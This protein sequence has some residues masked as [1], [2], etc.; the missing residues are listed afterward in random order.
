MTCREM[1]I[2]QDEV[3][4][5]TVLNLQF[6]NQKNSFGNGISPHKFGAITHV[7]VKLD[8]NFWEEF[9]GNILC[10]LPEIINVLIFPISTGSFSIM[11]GIDSHNTF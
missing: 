7:A 2:A 11:Y 10:F 8:R 6:Q 1:V 4:T 9:N 3:N 5:T